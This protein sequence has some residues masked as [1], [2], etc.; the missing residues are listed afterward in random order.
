MSEAVVATSGAPATEYLAGGTDLSER[1]RSGLSQGELIDVNASPEMAG[2][3]WGSV[4][5]AAIGSLTTIEALAT[6]ARIASAYPGLAA[7]A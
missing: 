4:G 3:S 6:D 2:I 7:A 1:R 5:G